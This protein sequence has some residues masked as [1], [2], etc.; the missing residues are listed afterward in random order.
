[1]MKE[2]KDGQQANQSREDRP[3]KAE[4]VPAVASSL[5]VARLLLNL[6]SVSVMTMLPRGC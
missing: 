2:S 3:M 4:Q 5:R 6:V 1:M